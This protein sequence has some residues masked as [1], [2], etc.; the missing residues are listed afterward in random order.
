MVRFEHL[1][2]GMVITLSVFTFTLHWHAP[3]DKRKHVHLRTSVKKCELDATCD[4]LETCQSNMC[5]HFWPVSASH[6][7]ACHLRCEQDVRLYEDHFYLKNITDVKP[8]AGISNDTCVISYRV[9]STTPGLSVSEYVRQKRGS[10]L[11]TERLD[12]LNVAFCLKIEQQNSIKVQEKSPIEH[13][14]QNSTKVQEK[15]PI[16]QHKMVTTKTKYVSLKDCQPTFGVTPLDIVIPLLDPMDPALKRTLRSFEKNGLLDIVRHVHVITNSDSVHPELHKQYK[17]LRVVSLADVNVSFEL[18][19][20]KEIPWA[21]MY[22]SAFVN[23]L[24]ANYIMTPDDTI[25]N[26]PVLPEYLFDFNKNTQYAH[27][28]GTAA[29]GNTLGYRNI[30]P[31]H[32]PNL[33][34]TCAMKFIIN[35]Y[36]DTRPAIDPISVTL[37]EMNSEGLISSF[38]HSHSH[39]FRD[40]AGMDYYSE[41]HTNGGCSRPG[42]DDLFVNIH[43][44]SKEYDGN[45]QLKRTFDTYFEKQ[46]PTASR[47]E[48]TYNLT[49]SNANSTVWAN[50]ESIDGSSAHKRI[51][52]KHYSDFTPKMDVTSSEDGKGY[53]NIAAKTTSSKQ[54]FEKMAATRGDPEKKRYGNMLIF[55][56]GLP[57]YFKRFSNNSIFVKTGDIPDMWIRD[58]TAQVWPLRNDGPFVEKVL[59]MQSF[60]ILQD[61]YANSYRDHEVKSPTL[62]DSN[63]DRAGWVAT[64]N[65]ELDSGCY[66]IR[67]LY[68]AWKHHDLSVQKYRQ[69]VET[70]VNT[71]KTEQHHE[72]K[73]QYRYVELP[74]NGLG[75]PVTW[76]GMTWSGFRP[77]DDACT[78][79]YHIPSNLF[80]AYE[81]THVV[82]MFPDMV[83]AKV[84]SND[85]YRG[86]QK[87][88]TWSDQDGVVRYCYEVD[89]LGGCNKMD[90]ANVPS[91]LSI[92]Y[93]T[94]TRTNS[95]SLHILISGPPRSGTTLFGEMIN[96]GLTNSEIVFELTNPDQ[97]VPC[98]FGTPRPHS[99]KR[100]DDVADLNQDDEW[101]KYVQNVLDNCKSTK[102]ILKDPIALKNAEKFWKK[103]IVNKVIIKIREPLG[104]LESDCRRHHEFK[105]EP[106]SDS[107]IKRFLKRR[108]GEF[109]TIL[110]YES[111]YGFH[112]DWMFVKHEQWA[113][114]PIE[115]TK[116]L[117]K[118]L[119]IDWNADIE[120]WVREHTEGIESSSRGYHDLKFNS[121]KLIGQQGNLLTSQ[122]QHFIKIE[123]EKFRRY[124][125]YTEEIK[126][127][128]K[129]DIWKNTYD[130][131]WSSKNP[132]FFTGTAAEGIGSP[133]TPHNYIW[134]MSLVMRGLVDSSVSTEMRDRIE[135]TKVRG[136][137][138]ES[139]HKDDPTR[140]TREDFS[141]PNEL[142]KEFK[143]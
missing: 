25:L 61:P 47:Y 20:V 7:R 75:T 58:S 32:G 103:D 63:L 14:Q 134:P 67:L 44:I 137:L 115:S 108:K 87:H 102:L 28:F 136:K 131:I 119:D 106:C 66:F 46:F 57:P 121:E 142:Y 30:A 138:H 50:L 4:T 38:F 81:L 24:A 65:Y 89:G 135:K 27:S 92:P 101:W 122:Q 110:E 117:M 54:I 37:G 124:F 8:F 128:P 2:F 11:R 13:E 130:W 55:D 99:L 21:K 77:S 53:K 88:G 43:G 123:T 125:G 139:F 40:I 91:L 49:V 62:S 83:S 109:Q 31:L 69:T 94:E 17:G 70:L 133:H 48:T 90:D 82:N 105:S 16:E 9:V 68:Y 64:R 107:E 29:T 86:V 84:L 111:R 72:E 100:T 73:S 76:T 113:L 116:N 104:L 85:I 36:K 129:R 12:D 45:S 141:W 51:F 71:W 59:N 126:W 97:K 42:F 26:N 56:L 60:F 78:Y 79:G 98:Q 96:V 80:A 120:R 3:V 95:N 5:V 143:I 35:K 34:N 74:R 118:W 33:L 10:V 127:T 19:D 112:P 52:F 1:F 114:H 22:A 15:S 18:S 23:G 39:K 140:L 93:F 41:C 132:Y 6:M